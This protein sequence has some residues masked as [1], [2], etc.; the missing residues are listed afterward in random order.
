MPQTA[1][2]G[3]RLPEDL[4]QKFKRKADD[5]ERRKPSDMLRLLIE[6]F[7]DEKPNGQRRERRSLVGAK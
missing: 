4:R 2:I 3:C 1:Y 5:E 7:V 6:R